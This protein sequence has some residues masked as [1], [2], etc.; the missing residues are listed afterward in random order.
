MLIFAPYLGGIIGGVM[1][2]SGAAAT[3][4]GLAFLGGGSL[5]VG[6]FGMMGGYIAV[7]AGGALIGYKSSDSSYQSKVLELSKEEML[8]S[9]AKLTSILSLMH[10]TKDVV[11][12]FCESARL[13]QHE[14]EKS[15]DN[16]F[17][18]L[19]NEKGNE[20]SNKAEILIAFRKLIREHSTLKN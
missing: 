5:A 17:I 3:S 9:C 16:N 20:D 19:N 10:K 13:L 2:L 1:G 11:K 14:F 15:A 18:R 4:A 7:M 8:I 12:Q 6:G